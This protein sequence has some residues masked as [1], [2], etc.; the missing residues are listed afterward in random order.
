M[1]S[2]DVALD[3][4]N[5]VIRTSYMKVG[6]LPLPALLAIAF[7]I[8]VSATVWWLWKYYQY[9]CLP[10]IGVWDDQTQTI[11]PTELRE[12]ILP[13]RRTPRENQ[14]DHATNHANM[15]ATLTV[16]VLAWGLFFAALAIFIYRA[17]TN[18]NIQY[19]G[20][21]KP[22]PEITRFQRATCAY[23]PEPV[24]NA[25]PYK[26]VSI[27]GFFPANSLY[28]NCVLSENHLYYNMGS[29]DRPNSWK[30]VITPERLT[31][32]YISCQNA[33]FQKILRTHPKWVC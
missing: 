23:P 14:S 13:S 31:L 3:R 22:T 33:E 18:P 12:P 2:A 6:G 25:T 27:G 11:H 20:D 16:L 24:T 5:I 8:T 26:K 30:E 1:E 19:N 9:T 32:L 28:K 29:G 10:H 17:K 7:I 15:W 4:T 21:L